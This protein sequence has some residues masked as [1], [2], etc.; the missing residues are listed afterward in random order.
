[1]KA[2]FAALLNVFLLCQFA[3]GQSQQIDRVK[4][5]TDPTIL[6]AT[7]VT[8]LS[9]V[10]NHGTEGK[11]TQTGRF[12]CKLPDSTDANVKIL[13]ETRGHNRRETCYVPPLRLVFNKPDS[14]VLSSLKSLKLV[15]TCKLADVYTQYLMK[16]YLIYKMYNLFTEKS[17]RVRLL[18]LDYVDSSGKKKP[19]REFAFFTE[20][21]KEMAKR[22]S[23]KDWNEGSPHPEATDREQMTL[24][25][26]FE[27]MIG[28]TDWSVPARHNIKTIQPKDPATKPFAVPYDFD[29]SGLVNTDYSAPDPLLNTETVL[30]RVYRG[31]PRTMEELNKVLDLFNKQKEN[32]YAIINNCEQLDAR[33]KKGMISYLDEFYNSIK[34]P[35]TVKSIFIDNARIH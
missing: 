9:K 20:D 2:L 4:F 33:N 3:A 32:I 28:N 19:I 16:E 27:Y 25:T 13:I 21:V 34:N 29:Y 5:F 12:M 22:S 15:S 8:T 26:M 30:E 14:T 35:K 6:K 17:F 23:C 11:N 1:M 24:V 31:F 18:D 7:L 10:I